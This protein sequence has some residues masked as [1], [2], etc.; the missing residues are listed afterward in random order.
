MSEPSRWIPVTEKLPTD[1]SVKLVTELFK[2]EVRHLTFGV[3]DERYNSWNEFIFPHIV[4]VK[5]R[6]LAWR[7]PPEIYNGEF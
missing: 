6:V 1:R 5:L 4:G 2:G 3:W 7:E